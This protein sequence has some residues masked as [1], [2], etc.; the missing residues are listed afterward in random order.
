MAPSEN[1]EAAEQGLWGQSTAVSREM[2]GAGWE[3]AFN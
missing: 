3:K 1:G 2:Q